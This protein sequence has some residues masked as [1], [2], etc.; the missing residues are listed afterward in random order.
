VIPLP[1]VFDLA[2]ALPRWD[3]ALV[4]LATF[5]QLRFGELAALTR[6]H[7]WRKACI[8]CGV[9]DAHFHDYADVCVIGPITLGV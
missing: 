8:A 5:A 7:L 2:N 4:L 9:P 1:V 6:D 3:H